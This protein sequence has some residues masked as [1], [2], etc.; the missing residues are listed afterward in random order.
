VKKV[1]A[2]TFFTELERWDRELQM[3]A[4]LI[5]PCPFCGG[6]AHAFRNAEHEYYVGCSDRIEGCHVESSTWAVAELQMAI[7]MWNQRPDND[8]IANLEAQRD[9][10]FNE[11][12]AL[13]R[14]LVALQKQLDGKRPKKEA[15]NDRH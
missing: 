3:N 4:N 10:L 14:Q 2:E 1:D 5:L 7:D 9:G 11:N 12:K 8:R 6:E 13:Y 15:A